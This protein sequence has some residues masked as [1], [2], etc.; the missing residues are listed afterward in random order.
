MNRTLYLKLSTLFFL[1]MFIWGSWYVTTG[2][3]LLQTAGFSGREVGLIYTTTALAATLAPFLLGVVAD[4]FIA[5]ERLLSLL[6]GAG[7]L[8]MIAISFFD[9]FALF[10]PVL[11]LYSLLYM[12]T[13][14]LTSALCFHNL[15][16]G[17]RDFPRVRV[18]GTV[19]WI[20]AGLAISFF[21]LEPTAV[22]MRVSAATSLL[23]S[24][25][26]FTLPHTPPQPRVGKRSL[27]D[28]LG[29]E[30]LALLRRPSFAVLI[31]SLVLIS[32]PSGFYYS[33]TNSFLTEVGVANPAG[34]MTAGQMSEVVLMLFMPLFFSR[35]G[36]KWVIAVGLFAWGAR[37][38]LFAWGD[39]GPGAWMLWLG[40]LLHGVAFN[41][42]ALSGQIYIDQI[43]PRHVRSTAQGF[44]SMATLGFGALLGAYI[45]GEVVEHFTVSQQEHLWRSIWMVPA[46]IGL[47]VTVGFVLLFRE[48][49]EGAFSAKV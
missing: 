40:I 42:T 38:A 35:L 18:W 16:H 12:P 22:P 14:A 33:F 6:H 47:V 2:T 27:K 26:C 49:R 1:Q 15:Q 39:A 19:G 25:F 34:K 32:I 37:Y 9:S 11:I 17:A 46:A 10:F 41:F 7:G 28:F 23:T 24:V 45:A 30:V 20:V 29:P 4:R 13:F 31:V 44:M 48:P 36:F 43:A 8:L 3:Y 5:T 21:D